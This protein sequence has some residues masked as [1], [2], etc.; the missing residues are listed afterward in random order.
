MKDSQ[1]TQGPGKS[2]F[3][4]GQRVVTLLVEIAET[5]LR[6]LV[7]EL[8]EE[9]SNLFQL[10]LM[11]GLTLLFAAFGLMSLLVMVIWAVDPQY[12]L[13]V[14]IATTAILLGLALIGGIWTLTKA[15]RS[16][17]LRQSRKALEHDR[18]LLEKDE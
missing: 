10:L 9:K 6:L 12:R 4:I 1:N 16:T 5:R 13:D 8:E 3:G 15:R 11:L 17:L 18:Q 14:L 7:I 2:L